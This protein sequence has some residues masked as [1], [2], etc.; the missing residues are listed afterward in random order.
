MINDGKILIF[1]VAVAVVAP[2]QMSKGVVY[3]I[4]WLCVGKNFAVI[5]SYAE[6][7]VLAVEIVLQTIQIA[8]AFP[9]AHRQV[10]E[11]I[12]AT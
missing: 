5:K 11:Q 10:V 1:C 2:Q 9:L 7:C 4:P 12:V 8:L 6:F 3:S